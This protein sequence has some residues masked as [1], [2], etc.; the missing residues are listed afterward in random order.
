MMSLADYASHD[1]LGLAELLRRRE[2]TPKEL[3]QC[4]LAAIEAVNPRL[5]A[6]IDLYHD[7]I[8]GLGETA[9]PGPFHGVPILTKDFPL[10]KGRSAEFGSV[11]AKG[12][13]ASED[14][15]FWERLRDGGLVNIGRTTTS[16]FGIAAAT[17]TA[18]YGATRNPWDLT[19]SVAG[20][21]GG[22][23]A[24]VAAG[25]VPCAHGSDGG[26]SIRMPAAFCGIVGLKPSRGR[27]SHAPDG[28]ESLLGLATEFLLTKSIRDT[29]ALLDLTCAPV[30]G[31]GYEIV[32][33]SGSYV[34]RLRR[35]RRTCVLPFVRPHGPVVCW[36][37][38]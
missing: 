29:A 21:S 23:A 38:M 19:R 17:E 32:Q 33:P 34:Q 1:A 37:R 3:G 2:V 20:S 22:S 28:N 35:H 25:I 24:A 27:I 31:D 8:A 16:E 13:V 26:G 12:H 6:V 14:S 30:P 18:L 9:G 5:N 36:M 4:A 15:A 10:A 7:A 11:L